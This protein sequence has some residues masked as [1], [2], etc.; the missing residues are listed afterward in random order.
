M[1]PREKAKRFKVDEKELD[2]APRSDGEVDPD[3]ANLS[4]DEREKAI[5]LRQARKDYELK[6]GQPV[7]NSMKNNIERM[8]K[9]MQEEI[10]PNNLPP[11]E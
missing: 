1:D 6:F 7:P 10:D 9:K 5:M 8:I 3:L 4:E 11:A 2:T